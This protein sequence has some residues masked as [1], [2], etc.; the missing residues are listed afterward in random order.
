[1]RRFAVVVLTILMSLP[2]VFLACGGGGGGGG[3]PV[4]PALTAFEGDWIGPG[5]D[6]DQNPFIVALTMDTSGGISVYEIDDVPETD[7]VPATFV[8]EDASSALI[9]FDDSNNG[10]LFWDD[11]VDHILFVDPFI[12]VVA[13]VE[14]N[15]VV[16]PSYL[17]SDGVGSWAGYA[18]VF[19]SDTGDFEKESPVNLT[20]E[21][22]LSFAG[23][24]PQNNPFTGS[25][26]GALFSSSHGMYVGTIGGPPEQAIQIFLSPDLTFSG[27][28]LWEAGAAWPLAYIFVVLTKQ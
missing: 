12:D 9:T 3:G 19:D 10:G 11:A 4:G 22:D 24:D 23:T 15:A 25:F 13:V 14:K 1:M 6:G 8:V 20:V 2:L 18:Y 21:N 7:A 27:G 26:N 5:D 17:A 16:R 28:I